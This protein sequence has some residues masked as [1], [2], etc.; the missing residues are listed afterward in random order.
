MKVFTPTR[1]SSHITEI[2]D[3]TGVSAYLVTGEEK[4]VLID[5]CTGVKGLKALVESLTD[6]PITVLLTHSHGDHSG[7]IADFDE[8]WIHPD[9]LRFLKGEGA[10]GFEMRY[11]FA[12]GN[13]PDAGFTPDDMVPDP[14]PDK[15]YQFLADG[16]VFD[17][18]GFHVETIHVA[19]HTAGSCTFLFQ[20]ERS[21]L[22]G[23]ALNTNTLLSCR[24]STTIETYKKSLLHLK[25][26]DDRYDVAYYSHGPA[27]GP[28]SC[29]DDNLE[30]CDQILEGTDFGLEVPALGGGTAYLAAE[31]EGFIERKDGKFGNIVYD[32][33]RIR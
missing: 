1:V 17:L 22:Y 26:Y 10:S 8:V 24:E 27:I 23:D 6:L 21:M 14:A 18:G 13:A 4:A 20:E 31:R 9:D 29:I 3:I 28:K 19:G 11:G 12:K 33:A 16:M 5:T 15:E 25:T 2:R 30:L 32:R 7:S